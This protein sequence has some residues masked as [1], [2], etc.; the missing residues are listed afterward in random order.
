MAVCG[1][2]GGVA[3]AANPTISLAVTILVLLFAFTLFLGTC[4]MTPAFL[5]YFQHEIVIF[6]DISKVFLI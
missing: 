1:A 6:L 4:Y 3:R 5:S 2:E